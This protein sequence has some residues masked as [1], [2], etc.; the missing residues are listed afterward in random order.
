MINK[1]T[2][3]ILLIYIIVLTLGIA[4]YYTIPKDSFVKAITS[5]QRQEFDIMLQ[6]MEDKLINL[7]SAELEKMYKVKNW[8]FDLRGANV[9]INLPQ[10]SERIL[11]YRKN[12][13]DDKIEVSRYSTPMFIEDIDF[14]KDIKSPEIQLINNRISINYT[15]QKYSYSKF[16][17][18]FTIAQFAQNQFTDD[19]F[20]R[21]IFGQS[22]LYIKVTKGLK[23]ANEERYKYVN[24]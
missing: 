21:S 10:N 9:E 14:S 4:F 19:N 24:R 22:V 2:K 3:I 6:S 16:K 20:N 11:L 12:V 18:D 7:S 17:K 23:I 13:D 5:E 15:K 1:F 8:S